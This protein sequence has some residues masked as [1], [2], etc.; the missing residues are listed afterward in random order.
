MNRRDRECGNRQRADGGGAE[1]KAAELA[2]GH[3]GSSGWFLGMTG[4]DGSLGRQR[5][6]AIIAGLIAG[7]P[8]PQDTRHQGR[9]YR[10]M[11]KSS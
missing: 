6:F 2:A 4:F 10:R 1:R 7:L 11:D 3:E 9:C 8:M 5:R